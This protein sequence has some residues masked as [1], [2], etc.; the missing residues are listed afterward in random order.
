MANLPR[1]TVIKKHMRKCLNLDQDIDWSFPDLQG[2]FEAL[3][4]FYR[5]VD[6]KENMLNPD[7]G[8][9]L[10]TLL[11]LPELEWFVRETISS[12]GQKW[13]GQALRWDHDSPT[14]PMQEIRDKWIAWHEMD[15]P[16]EFG[17]HV[18]S[19]IQ[20]LESKSDL[21]SSSQE[22]RENWAYLHRRGMGLPGEIV[23]FLINVLTEM[24][25][26]QR[27]TQLN[28]NQGPS[29]SQ[30]DDPER[31]GGTHQPFSGEIGMISPMNRHVAEQTEGMPQRDPRLLVSYLLNHDPA[32]RTEEMRQP[33]SRLSASSLLNDD[34]TERT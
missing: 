15:L 17:G 8:Q 5:D 27:A 16:P 20:V 7:L 18:V 14:S 13:I 32:E 12:W 29:F 30:H 28:P 3:Q 6:P 2:R 1:T 21:L 26:L 25:P 9:R 31:T 34:V 22:D 33:S 24:C 4:A 19:Q 23:D 11:A 10:C